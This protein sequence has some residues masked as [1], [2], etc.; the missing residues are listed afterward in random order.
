LENHVRTSVNGKGAPFKEGPDRF[1]IKASWRLGTVEVDMW[2]VF[3]SEDYEV[4]CSQ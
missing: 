3:P 4:I 2:L 1:L